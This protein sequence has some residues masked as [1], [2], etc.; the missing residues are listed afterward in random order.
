MTT[1][2]L[3]TDQDL[4]ALGFS[5]E[6][7]GLINRCIGRLLITSDALCELVKHVRLRYTKVEQVESALSL[8]IENYRENRSYR[9]RIE[10]VGDNEQQQAA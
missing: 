2:K 3:P 4:L 9:N 6:Q 7:I 8:L 1:T 5:A 10:Q